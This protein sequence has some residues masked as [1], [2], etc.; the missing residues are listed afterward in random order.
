MLCR[1]F[2]STTNRTN[3]KVAVLGAAG[4]IGQPLSLLLKLNS[5][6]TE[7]S[8]YDLVKHTP[9]VGADLSHIDRNSNTKAST[10]PEELGKALNGTELVV[11]PAGV[12]RKPGMTRDD[13]FGTNASIVRDL[14]EG[15]CKYAPKA[16]IT[17]VTN[18]VNSC[19]PIAAEVMKKNGVF[20]PKRLIGVTTLDV[21]RSSTFVANLKGLDPVTLQI[22]VIVGHSGETIVPLLS[23][24]QPK[25]ELSDDEIVSLTERI[26]NAGT[27]VVKAKAGAGS[28]TLSMAY[29][30]ARFVD[31]LLRAMTGESNVIE[32]SFVAHEISDV[33]YF[34]SPLLLGKNGVEKAFGMPSLSKF[35]NELVNIALPILKKNIM[36]G[37]EFVNTGKV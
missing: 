22:P 1:R 2:F 8:L 37:E 12:P 28:A 5:L 27:E 6:V 11:I 34:A 3:V 17:V 7:L 16:L 19:V 30:G 26:Q 14:V 18:P 23:H 13:L 10:G 33:N 32:C 29:S 21:V 9:G 20:D 4:G 36:K 15:V 31:S 35:E 24:C 25:V